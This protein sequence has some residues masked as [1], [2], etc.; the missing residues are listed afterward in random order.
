VTDT[1]AVVGG[2]SEHKLARLGLST[3]SVRFQLTAS[4]DA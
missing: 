4:G 2:Q 3:W 1:Q